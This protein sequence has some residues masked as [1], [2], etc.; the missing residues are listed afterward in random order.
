MTDALDG[1]G[2]QRENV[3]AG[4]GRFHCAERIQQ[5]RFFDAVGRDGRDSEVF[6]GRHAMRGALRGPDGLPHSETS[7]GPRRNA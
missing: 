2:F 1:A 7:T 5:L 6:D 4:T 3:Y